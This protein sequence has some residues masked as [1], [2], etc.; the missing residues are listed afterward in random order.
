M[1]HQG[2]LLAAVGSF[3]D[4][5]AAGG[6][7]LVRIE[8]LDR[9]RVLPGC[10]DEML[11]T[12]RAFGLEWDGAIEYQSARLAHY[13][14]ALESL[15]ARE[16]S[17]PCSCSRR[18][19]AEERGYPGTCRGGPKPS[20]PAAIRFR[21]GA[22]RNP[23]RLEDRC[24]AGSQCHFDSPRSSDVP[25]VRRR[26]GTFA[27]QLAVVVDDALQG[28]TDVVR[29]ADLLDS[30]PWQIALQHALS[31]ETPRY[32]H[33]PLMTEADGS[34]L[35]KSRRSVALEPERAGIQLIEALKRLLG[36]PLEPELEREPVGRILEWAVRT[37][38]PAA[39]TAGCAGE[40]G[41]DVAPKLPLQQFCRTAV[42]VPAAV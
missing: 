8:D 30:T 39:T 10:A 40:V 19:L 5:R 4:A 28:V 35:A 18:E 14:A 2:S 32:A 31:F 12:L 26:D 29:G 23:F 42:A 11:R 21:I 34:K 27:Y 25:V 33:L 1:L 9:E 6:R 15:T 36:Q 13:A 7:W 17:F 38:G 24:L 16:L 41:A 20:G 37:L 3:L 22:T